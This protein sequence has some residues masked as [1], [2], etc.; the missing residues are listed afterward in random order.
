MAP[1]SDLV[2]ALLSGQSV[3]IN[4]EKGRA[5]I[6]ST[7]TTRVRRVSQCLCIVLSL[8]ADSRYELGYSAASLL[9]PELGP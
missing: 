9:K 8:L 7:K 4:L 6:N 5:M 3:R 2:T 1:S